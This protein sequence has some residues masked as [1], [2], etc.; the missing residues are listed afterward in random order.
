MT[1]ILSRS[2]ALA[3]RTPTSRQ[4]YLD[5]LRAFS[6]SV[7]VLGHWLLAVVT[8]TDAAGAVAGGWAYGGE[9]GLRTGSLLAIAPSTQW[10]TWLF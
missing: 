4:R 5:F 6:L 10:L 9:S 2:A 1:Q 3:A 7:V 8:R